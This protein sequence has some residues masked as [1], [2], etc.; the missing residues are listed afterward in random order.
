MSQ[1]INIL[2]VDDQQIIIDGIMSLLHMHQEISIIGYANNGKEAIERVGA[3]LPDIVLLDFNMPG[4]DG[5]E[6]AQQLKHLYPTVKIL[7]LTGYDEL[8]LIRDALKKG[9]D[10]YVLKNISKGELVEALSTIMLGKKYL[11]AHVQDKI[12]DSFV[13]DISSQSNK[14]DNGLDKFGLTK[15]EIEILRLIAHGKTSTE[16][17]KELYISI[18]TVD[19]HR[20]NLMS[21]CNTKNSIE[22]VKLAMASGIA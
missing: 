2:I 22:L 7:M 3:L 1:K 11:D 10:G 15:R 9:A 4:M 17:G 5:I 12:I 20:K 18:N 21:K 14:K 8:E 6:T 19:T 13:H 16:I